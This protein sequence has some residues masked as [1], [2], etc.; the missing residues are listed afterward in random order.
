V[1]Q[2]PLVRRVPW[3]HQ[4]HQALMDNLVLRVQLALLD[5]R[6]HLDPLVQLGQL[7][8]KEVPV[9]LEIQVGQVHEG[10]IQIA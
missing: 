5:K 7:E 9:Q 2:G 6:D 4:V 3:G 10:C 1:Q 8:T